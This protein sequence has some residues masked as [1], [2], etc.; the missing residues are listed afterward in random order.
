MLQGFAAIIK[1]LSNR[2]LLTGMTFGSFCFHILL[3][4]PS[5]QCHLEILNHIYMKAYQMPI[6]ML[7][8]H[9]NS[10]NI[11]KLGKGFP[12]HWTFYRRT[13]NAIPRHLRTIVSHANN[14]TVLT[15]FFIHVMGMGLGN[16]VRNIN[17][18]DAK[19]RNLYK[20]SHGILKL[21]C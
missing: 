5:L 17:P 6:I 19:L 21:P 9:L 4:F 3:R 18:D 14:I 11:P 1:R 10:R 13:S 2:V 15:K 16:G 8:E 7:K 20:I 12:Q